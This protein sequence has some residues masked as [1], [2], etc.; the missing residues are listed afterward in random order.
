VAAA[1]L[2]GCFSS[3]GGTSPPLD[4]LYFPV[5]LSLIG[6]AEYLAVAN[7]DYDL[8]YNAGT[9]ITLDLQKLRALTPTACSSDEN[10]DPSSRCDSFPSVENA[11]VPSYVCVARE[12]DAAGLPCRGAPER[13][14]SQRLLYPGRCQH[15]DFAAAGLLRDGVKIGA[16]ATDVIHSPR[17]ASA[18]STNPAEAGRLFVPVRGDATLHWLSVTADGL[19]DCGQGGNSGACDDYHRVGDDPDQENARDLRLD[20]EPFAVAASAN[21]EAIAISN[22]TSGRVALFVNDWA[23]GPKLKS[24]LTGLPGYPVGLVSLPPPGVATAKLALGELTAELDYAPGF[25]VTYSNAPEVD[26]LRYFENGKNPEQPYLTRANAAGIFINSSGFDSR[27]IAVDASIRD[28]LEAECDTRWAV[29]TGCVGDAACVAELSADPAR[30]QGYV[31][32]LA[33]ASGTPVDVYVAN[34]APASLLV[35][36][37]RP[38]QNAVETSE[39]PE[40][41]D[42]VPLTLG[43]SRVLSGRVTVGQRADG[44]REF[45]QRVFVACFDSERVFVYDPAR[46]R[47]ETEIATGR[48]PHAIAIDADNGLLYVAHFTDSYIGVVSIDRRHPMTYGKTLASIGRPTPP[49][50]SK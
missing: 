48:G 7:S 23:S 9:L 29:P 39:I 21:G 15:I 26:L 16:F 37:T 17:P 36:R 25:L 14:L 38:I 35:G 49:R 3:S 46:R 2:G 10:C 32:C 18:D 50:T 27:G 24:V 6:N 8:H 30:Q 4:T 47:L 19:L 42:T 33:A 31:A 1:L 41:Y 34:R 43:P 28:E 20:P 12:G 40:F 22:R 5:G 44:T 11:Q 45:E 13:G